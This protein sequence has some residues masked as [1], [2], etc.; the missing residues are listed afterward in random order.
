MSNI[1]V[2]GNQSYFNED[3]KFFKDVYVYG[4]L[5]YD[6][7]DVKN[8]TVRE[9][10]NLGVTT[11]TSLS[12]QNL[13]VFGIATV[14]QLV[15]VGVGSTIQIVSGSKLVGSTV[16]SV[17]APGNIVQVTSVNNPSNFNTTSGSYVA[18]TGFAT[19]ITPLSASNKYYAIATIAHV[20]S[21]A[22][23]ILNYDAMKLTS[24]GSGAFDNYITQGYVNSNDGTGYTMNS[25]SAFGTFTNAGIHTFAIFTAQ[26][27]G[28]STTVMNSYAGG[29]GIIVSN[30]TIFEI[31]G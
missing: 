4:N 30:L 29:A 3:A 12:A 22:A 6:S 2:S 14:A 21:Y 26:S 25:I 7:L 31:A 18:V 1:T 13:N 28:N 5:Y 8:L 11:T 9:Q 17:Y 23:Q 20:N 10:S 24:T 27:G 16:G 15:G 19:T